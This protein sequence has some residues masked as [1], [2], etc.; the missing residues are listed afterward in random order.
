MLRRLYRC[1][2]RLHPPSFRRRFGDEMLYIFDQQKGMQPGL[3]L[4]LESIFSLFRQWVLRPSAGSELPAAPQPAPTA[5]HIPSFGT[6]DTFRP[7]ASAI[8]NGAVLSLLLFCMTVFAIRYSWS[9]VLNLHIR[10]I[11][12]DWGQQVRPEAAP[13]RSAFLQ[14]DPYVGEYVS[15][16][17]PAAISI[18]IEDNHLALGVTQRASV[19]LTPVS[20]KRFMIDGVGSNYVDFD[21]D[22]WG[23]IC[24]LS[25]VVNGKAVAARRR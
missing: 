9:H 21:F 19:P 23:R 4:I 16:S 11:G 8:L 18:R 7:R 25:L 17:P 2:V 13:R 22:V 6:F 5:D 1:V 24:G 10:E 14:L 20:P 12:T 15:H 3:G